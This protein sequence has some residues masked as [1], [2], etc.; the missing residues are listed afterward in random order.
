MFQQFVDF[1]FQYWKKWGWFGNYPTWQA[2]ELDCKG[3]DADG[4]FERV[5]AAS[6][7]VQRG[8]AAYERDSVLFFD[9]E[10]NENLIKSLKN[11]VDT[12]GSVRVLDFG[13]SLGS[14]FFQ[15]QKQ[16]SVFKNLIWCVVE[17]PH[18]VAAGQ[19]EFETKTLKFEPTI[20]E[21][22]AKYAP[23]VA[24]FSSVLQYLPQPF[25]FIE[26]IHAA[27]IPYLFIDRTPFLSAD[28][29]RITKQIVPSKIYAASYPCWLFSEKRFKTNLEKYYEIESEFAA[30]DKNNVL[31]CRYKGF[32]CRLKL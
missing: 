31:N 19:G 16:L 25:S 1:Y 20:A 23:N 28:V 24:V 5:V 32:F 10:T 12:E 27:K 8:Q 3:Y 13:G 14:T 4:I 29:D 15:H 17:Q 9:E 26:A 18:F 30:L 2:A 11:V 6:R 7:A 21:A 22:V